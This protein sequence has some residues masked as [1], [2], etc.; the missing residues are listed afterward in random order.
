[1]LR[2]EVHPAQV[3]G[4]F[5]PAEPETLNALTADA[6]VARTAR[7]DSAGRPQ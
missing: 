6:R 3:A 7:T 4:M 1:M 2:S 5:Y